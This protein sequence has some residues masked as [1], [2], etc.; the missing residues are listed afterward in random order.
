MNTFSLSATNKHRRWV[1]V[2]VLLCIG[3]FH[4]TV[5]CSACLPSAGPSLIQLADSENFDLEALDADIENRLMR[6]T[7]LTKTHKRDHGHRLLSLTP[8]YS[9]SFRY[10]TA[11]AS[12]MRSTMIAMASR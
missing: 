8:Q 6:I 11:Y 3:F 10:L 7:D 2:F 12:R 5:T 4:V 9:T 1:A